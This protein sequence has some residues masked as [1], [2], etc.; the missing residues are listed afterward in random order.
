MRIETAIREFLAFIKNPYWSIR[1]ANPLDFLTATKLFFVVFFFEMLLFLPISSIIGLENVPHAMDDLLNGSEL[2]KV[3]ALAVIF[4][5]IAEELLFRLHLKYRIAN[6]VFL[7]LTLIG[8][9]FL[10]IRHYL[11]VFPTDAEGLMT[12]FATR[13]FLMTI[14]LVI[15]FTVAGVAVMIIRDKKA[16]WLERNFPFVFYLTALVFAMIHISNFQ[17]PPEQWYL[18]PLIVLPQFILGCYLG[19]IRLRNNIGYSIYIHALN[20]LIPMTLVS[21]SGMY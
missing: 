17:L 20:N 8:M 18:G 2:W 10:I 11:P 14:L 13:S 9:V 16:G 5:P 4:A 7:M 1:D 12:L 15:V 6:Y 19:Y 3:A 21:L